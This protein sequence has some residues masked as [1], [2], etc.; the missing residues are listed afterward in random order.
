M[1]MFSRNIKMPQNFSN[2]AFVF[3]CIWIVSRDGQYGIIFEKNRN[4]W[5]EILEN[6]KGT[7]SKS[8]LII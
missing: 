1:N 5:M 4:M 2:V 8:C 3:G 7:S 6:A